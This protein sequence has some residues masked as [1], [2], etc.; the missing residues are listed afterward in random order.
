MKP[1]FLVVMLKELRETLR[2]RRALFMLLL[3]VLMYPALVGGVLQQQINR[4]TQ[5]EKEGIELTVIGAR[6]APTLMTQL[7]QKN[8]NVHEAGP[9]TQEAIAALLRT[10]KVAAVLRVSDSYGEDYRAMR[11]ARIELWYDSADDNG[12]KRYDVED[13]LRNYSNTIAGARLLA[14]G[15]SPATLFPVH[16]QKYDTGTSAS[17]SASV[18]GTMLGMFFIP[19]F[20]FALATAVDSTAGERERRSL[21]VLLAQPA[22]TLDLVAG[23]WLAAALLSLAGLTLELCFAHG[24]LK[25]LPLEEIGMSWRLSWADLALVCLVSVSLPLCAA[26]LEIAL[27][28]NA[29]TFK[30]AQTTA[31]LAIFVPM[32][33]VIVVPMLD[34]T[35]QTWM[36][37]VPM[38][39]HQTLL[40]ELAK[41]Q[42]VGALP[43]VLTF[44]SSLAI[45]LLALWFTV[46]RMKSERYMIG[47]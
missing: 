22:S 28:I 13:V 25:W 24:I 37:A 31:S 32:V 46:R 1:M 10:R 34:L 26:A 40:R 45:A 19:A 23:K 14:H 27:A 12:R 36:Y 39:A 20:F 7:K 17:R 33:P 21:E 8:V 15:V 6:M 43:F 35:T 44:A 5:P 18:I 16:V 2:D 47:I 29:K 38:L 11:P 3:F 41:G 30:E 4:A 9:M 42:A